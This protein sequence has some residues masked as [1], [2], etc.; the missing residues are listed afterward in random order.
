[1]QVEMVL[2][3]L[4]DREG[5]MRRREFI[6]ALGGAMAWPV[7]ARAQ[8]NAGIRQ[9]GILVLGNAD[10]APFLN[11]FRSE[12]LKLGYIEGANI[13]FQYR[14][15]HGKTSLLPQ[16][17]AE[18]VKLK[19]D[20][21]VTWQT[22]PSIAAKEATSEIPIVMADSGDPIATGLVTGLAH[23]GGNVTGMTGQTDELAAKNVEFIGELIP[24]AHLIGILGNA[25]D[26][27][28][29]PFLSQIAK[30]AKVEGLVLGITAG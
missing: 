15:A 20:A 5:W 3:Y 9:I 22:P 10:P 25:T 2:T 27:F 8:Q 11:Y 1:M 6:T 13:A 30:A 12:L 21:I 14:S 4:V 28:T 26:A 18:L 7:V 17:A 23:P 19:V 24:D 29:N 16:L